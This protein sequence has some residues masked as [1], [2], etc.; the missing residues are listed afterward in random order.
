MGWTMALLAF[1]TFHYSSFIF[2][3]K[4]KN[5]TKMYLPTLQEN[6]LVP[7]HGVA[8]SNHRIQGFFCPPFRV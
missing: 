3:N 6:F 4:Y 8:V 1:E 7:P 2:D 5:Y